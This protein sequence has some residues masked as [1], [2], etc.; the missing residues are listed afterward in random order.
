MRRLVAAGRG[1]VLLTLATAVP[2]LSVVPAVLG[3]L[4]GRS[5]SP[6]NPWTWFGWLLIVSACALAL[7]RPIGTLVRRLANSWCGLQLEDGYRPPGP[8]PV[9]LSTGHWWNGHSYERT[10]RD[11]EMDARWRRGLGDPAY[12][13]DVR[14]L[15][16]SA[17]TIAPVCA[18]P[19]AALAGAVIAFTRS[20]V[21]VGIGLTLIGVL[22]APYA[23]LVLRPLAGRWLPAP[24]STDRVRELE[25]QR[26]DLTRSQ[27]AEIR[28]IERD[29]HDGAQARLVA[30]G[31]SLATAERLMDTDPDRAKA[32]LRE[33]REGTSTSLAQ[34]RDLVR[35]V[36]P[37]VL[38][39]RGLVDAIRALA[40]D[41][42]LE[43]T[44]ASD[45]GQRLDAPIEAAAYFSV[46]E[47]LA[48][49]TK[50]AEASTVQVDVRKAGTA[51]TVLVTDTGPGGAVAVP[52]GGLDGIARRLSAFDGTLT[53]DSP[54][55]GPT[56]ARME[57][58]CE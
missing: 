44:V 55:G 56:L 35:G 20:A 48:N 33:A 31:L 46:A 7:A 8:E 28:R 13:R 40:L 57:I 32:L 27:A 5:W 58:P 23:W 4:T 17:I 51:L 52:G 54:P 38:A 12:W 36:H 11:A 47:L 2:V 18:V 39:E 30:V 21:A 26:A 49:A 1:L 41:S 9:Q 16:I 42:A 45:L 15:G 53:L 29:L 37:P 3:A 24:D 10:R 43:V 19:P 6:A 25:L 22:T 34:L 50:Y 14:W